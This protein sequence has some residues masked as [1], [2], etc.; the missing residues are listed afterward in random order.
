MI[1][2]GNHVEFSGEKASTCQ[3]IFFDEERFRLIMAVVQI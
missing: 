1:D 3:R 2:Q